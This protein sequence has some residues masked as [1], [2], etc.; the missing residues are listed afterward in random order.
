MAPKAAA[1]AAKDT[2]KTGIYGFGS[3]SRSNKVV[4][5]TNSSAAKQTKKKKA[6]M[7]TLADLDRKNTKQKV[8]HDDDDPE[9]GDFVP[10]PE[11]GPGDDDEL[12]GGDGIDPGKEVYKTY[13]RENFVDFTRNRLGGIPVQ[14]SGTGKSKG[15]QDEVSVLKKEK[16]TEEA[17]VTS[18]EHGGDE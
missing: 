8:K 18:K 9:D 7:Y 17:V 15:D 3:T 10:N 5:K 6:G 2:R 4:K 16:K 14:E 11:D 13:T 1:K 12:L